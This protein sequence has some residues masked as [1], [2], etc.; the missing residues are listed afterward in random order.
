MGVGMISPRWRSHGG[1]GPH[2]GFKYHEGCLLKLRRGFTQVNAPLFQSSVSL[3]VNDLRV[4]PGVCCAKLVFKHRQQFTVDV[5]MIG[6]HSY[7]TAWPHGHEVRPL[8]ALLGRL[9]MP[10][11][12]A[13]RPLGF[14]LREQPRKD[15]IAQLL[16]VERHGL[17]ATGGGVRALTAASNSRAAF[18]AS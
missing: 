11:I 18:R 2:M 4:P 17:R 15:I 16:E 7:L 12:I 8:G 9:Q 6:R 1:I 5:S 14:I 13:I 3:R 10:T